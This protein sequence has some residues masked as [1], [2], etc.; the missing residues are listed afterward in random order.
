MP[1][2]TNRLAWSVT[3]QQ[4]LEECARKYYLAYY[5]AWGGWSADA[6]PFARLCYRLNH[7]QPLAMW[8][9]SV[10]H[11]TIEWVLTRLRDGGG[12][13]ELA[14]AH[15]RALALLRSGWRESKSREWM[16]A[17][18]RV[19]N[20]LEHYYR[21]PVTPQQANA[22]REEVLGAISRFH[23][24]PTLRRIGQT[25]PASWLALEDFGELAV[26][27][28]PVL[29]RI[30]FALSYEGVV[31]VFDWKT[32]QPSDA[33]NLAQLGVYGLHAVHKWGARP[34]TTRVH[35]LYLAD[36]R[37]VSR[38]L[39]ASA[40][41]ETQDRILSG[42]QAMSAL[43][44][45]PAEANRPLPIE[46]FEMTAQQARCTMCKFREICFGTAE[47]QASHPVA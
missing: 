32:G 2:L 45:G 30:D 26:E 21:M 34:E 9:G 37:L 4:T 36:G 35:L 40:I 24:S 17:P 47:E 22:L 31:H 13:P 28:A 25:E 12:V 42:L 33:E 5:G 38:Q 41:L 23:A 43:L 44:E 3:R 16:E 19:T 39:S 46:R 29:L 10:V 8:R 15:E 18:K 11:R 14:S 20:L 27:G 6:D 7:L 1:D